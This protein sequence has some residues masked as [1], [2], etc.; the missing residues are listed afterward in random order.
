MGNIDALAEVENEVDRL[1]NICL[2]D[3]GL[4][5]E[6][7]PDVA[8]PN[9]SNDVNDYLTVLKERVSLEEAEEF[10]YSKRYPDFYLVE[11]FEHELDEADTTH[12][13]IEQLVNNVARS[14]DYAL[15]LLDSG[16]VSDEAV[17]TSGFHPDGLREFVGEHSSGCN[18]LVREK[19]FDGRQPEWNAAQAAAANGINPQED[20]EFKRLEE[21]WAACMEEAGYSDVNYYSIFD[22][23]QEHI[24]GTITTDE[25]DQRQKDLAVSDALCTE[26]LDLNEQHK[27]IA[28]RLLRESI[29][30]NEDEFFAFQELA[31]EFSS[32]A[33]DMI[34]Q[35]TVLGE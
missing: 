11:N 1:I 31:E 4:K 35:D 9:E 25:F 10:G 28:T 32:R 5:D 15:E 33:Q 2:T 27:E 14:G 7:L 13:E 30:A 17:A 19:L 6:Y 18:G 8:T 24:F 3:L 12:S 23:Q 26:E 34:Q 21:D 29:E 22:L 20:P 16:E